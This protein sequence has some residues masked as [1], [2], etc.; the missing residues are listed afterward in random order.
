MSLIWIQVTMCS[1]DIDT[2]FTKSVP[3]LLEKIFFSLDY[4]SFQTCFRVNTAWNKLQVFQSYQKR[5]KSVFSNEIYKDIEK[6]RDA[7]AEGNVDEIKS[8]LFWAPIL[9]QTI[10]A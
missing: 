7:S 3:H 1:P 8:L 5:A 4:E 2:L 6:L 9:V 10:L